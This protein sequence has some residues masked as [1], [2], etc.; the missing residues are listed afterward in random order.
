MIVVVGEH[1]VDLVPAGEG[2][3]RAAL[4][5]GPA[6]VAIA[7]A[8][9]G[10]PVAMASRLGRDSFA[11]AFRARLEQSGVDVRYLVSTN[12][13]S[14][15]ALATVDKDAEAHYD[16][17]L[18][19][20]ADF[21]WRLHELPDLPEGSTIQLG[22]LA[23]FLPPGADTLERWAQSHR[24]R[25]TISF[26]PNIRTVAL[27]RPDSLVRLERLVGLSHIV[28][29]SE[30]DLTHA[31]PTATAMQTARRWLK[32]G[33]KLVV[34]THGGQG[35]TAL[36]ADGEFSVTAPK[37]TPVDTIGAGDTAMGALLAWLHGEGLLG[38]QFLPPPTPDALTRMLR[39]MVRAAAL[40]CTRPGANPPTTRELQAF[41][42]E[43]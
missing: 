21:G 23:A 24:D 35:A 19:G 17:W 41:G 13:P 8:R 39:Y 7:A 20:A 36:T 4:G 33:P 18:S 38:D 34:V 27:E 22:S 25:C 12:Q 37:I 40:T 31:Y 30:G 32:S 16:F 14:A 43:G 2:L 26:D 11:R 6:N 10:A 42:D 1:I 9:L 3:L 5:G 15:L 29:A 28:R